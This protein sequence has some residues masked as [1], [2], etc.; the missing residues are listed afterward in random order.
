MQR[1]LKAVRIVKGVGRKYEETLN[2][3]SRLHGN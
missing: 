1:R 2:V 3:S